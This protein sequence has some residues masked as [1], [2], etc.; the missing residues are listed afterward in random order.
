MTKGNFDHSDKHVDNVISYPNNKF[1]SEEVIS[2]SMRHV[3]SE[4]SNKR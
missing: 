3:V 2:G 4:P 1:V